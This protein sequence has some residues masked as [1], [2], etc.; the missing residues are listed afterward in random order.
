MKVLIINTSEKTGGAAVAANRLTEALIGN[1]VKAKMLVRNPSDESSMHVTHTGVWLQNKWNFLFER[2][3][4]W[5]RN[6]FDRENLFKV[7]IANTGQDLTKTREFQDADIIH[8]HW[9]N[10][11]FLSLRGIE[12]ILK[13]GKPVVWTM[14]DMWEA[15]AI[16]HHAYEC[17]NYETEC[18]D[19]PFL[20]KPGVK[21]MANQVFRKKQRVLEAVRQGRGLTFVAVSNWL[22]E[23]ARQS[24]LI[25]DL[26]ITVIPNSISMS[27]FKIVD[28]DDARTAL[29]VSEPYVISFGA[30][31]IDDPIKG[32]GYLVEA[33]RKLVDTGRVQSEQL[34]LLLFGGV[35]D[36]AIFSQLPVPY[37][38]LGYVSDEDQLS[39]IYSASN[40]TVSSSLYETFGQTLIEA[41]ACGSVPVS[42]DGSGQTDIIAHQQT[43]YLA[44][45]LSA[46]SLAEGIDWAIHANIAP[47]E[48]RRSVSRRYAESIVANRYYELYKG[49]VKSEE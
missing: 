27:R 35:R 6:G 13:S 29:D 4:I 36:T 1:G 7:S 8:L 16:C 20:K 3:V 22:A 45:R 38:Y 18:H 15:T 26:P 21:D 10:Q 12:K 33:L 40:A 17:R 48:L 42:F 25:G 5:L 49:K 39:L 44:Q 41:M 19:C 9:V 24:A 46:E 30:A 31:R 37:T 34:R 2:F 28:R 47:K 14:H 32:F 43:G 23:R 11:G